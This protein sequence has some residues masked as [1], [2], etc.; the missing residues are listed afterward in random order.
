M[1]GLTHGGEMP[2]EEP[3]ARKEIPAASE[4][5][6]G[7][8]GLN[9][10]DT[11]TRKGNPVYNVGGNTWDYRAV[12]SKVGGTFYKP[13]PKAKGVYSFKGGDWENTAE[14]EAAILKG[15]A[16]AGLKPERAGG[17]VEKTKPTEET[18]ST[19]APA[20]PEEAAEYH[21]QVWGR[22]SFAERSNLI[23]PIGWAPRTANPMVEKSWDK[24]SPAAQKL[25]AK[26]I[27]E[28]ATAPQP[29][30]PAESPETDAVGLIGGS[31]VD[32]VTARG[33]HFIRAEM[34]PEEY[35]IITGITSGGYAEKLRE[36]GITARKFEDGSTVTWFDK[37]LE[38]QVTGKV[39][40]K[41]FIKEGRG[42]PLAISVSQELPGTT[43]R[44]VIDVRLDE[45][46]LKKVTENEVAFNVGDRVTW[47]DGIMVQTG[48]VE[49]L[50]R[51]GVVE[52]R[53][54][55]VPSESLD[56]GARHRLRDW[57]DKIEELKQQ[58][59]MRND[60]VLVYQEL[61]KLGM[62]GN[63]ANVGDV[64]RVMGAGVVKLRNVNQ[65][66]LIETASPGETAK[67]EEELVELYS[68][69]EALTVINKEIFNTA[70]ADIPTGNIIRGDIE[71]GN[72]DAARMT[73]ENTIKT[74]IVNM[75]TRH[76]KE[77]KTGLNV[78]NSVDTPENI[79]GLVDQVLTHYKQTRG[80]V[81]PPQPK[82]EVD[83]IKHY[84]DATF[85]MITES[86]RSSAL[87]STVVENNNKFNALLSLSNQVKD[88][89][90]MVFDDVFD[91]DNYDMDAWNKFNTQEYVENLAERLYN[92]YKGGAKGDGTQGTTNTGLSGGQNVPGAHQGAPAENVQG[93]ER[94]GGAG[95]SSVPAPG[96][97]NRDPGGRAEAGDE[98]V[99]GPGSGQRGNLSAGRVTGQNYRITPEDNVDTRGPTQKVRDNI[100][101]LRVL[102]QL[103]AEQR[104]AT[105]DEQQALVKYVGWGF[106]KEMFN[107]RKD[108]QFNAERKELKELLTDE[109]WAE[110]RHSSQFAHYTSPEAI[111]AIYTA[112]EHMGFRGGRVLEPAMGV[113]HFFGLIPEK[114]AGASW[115]TGVE[116][117]PTAG[118]M[119]KHLYPKANINVMG[120]QDFSVPY[121]K[122]K[123][124]SENYYDAIVSNVPF[125]EHRNFI[126]TRYDHLPGKKNLHNYF[127]VKAMDQLRPGGILAF[128]TSRYTMDSMDES[129]RTYMAEKADFLGAVRLHNRAFKGIA[130]TQ[131]VTDVIF[132]QK[133]APGAEAKMPAWIETEEVEFPNAEARSWDTT[134]AVNEYFIQNPD[135]VLGTPTV[136]KYGMYGQWEYTVDPKV[137]VKGLGDMTLGEQIVKA[138]KEKMPANIYKAAPKHKSTE[139]AS[140][141]QLMP[142]PAGSQPGSF[143]LKDGKLYSTSVSEEGELVTGAVTLPEGKV[144]ERI[145]GLIELR[146]VFDDL[147]KKELSSEEGAGIDAARTK[148]NQVYD[149]FVKKHDPI[150]SLS[151]AMA[152]SGDPSY[153][154]LS[155]L[156]IVDP[157]AVD[158]KGKS[159][160]KVEKAAIFKQRVIRKYEPA[161]SAENAQEALY[162]ALNETGRLNFD[163]MSDLT[164]LS[165]EQIQKD[166]T[167]LIYKDPEKG[168]TMGDEYLSG[169]VREKLRIA[170]DAAKHDAAF[171]PNV[172]ALR[173]VQPVDLKPEEIRV[174]FGSPWIPPDV[175]KAF[176][177]D[178][179][180]IP[181][182]NREHI[183][184]VHVRNLGA[185]A[186]MLKDRVKST[187]RHSTENTRTYGIPELSA[188]KII[189]KTFTGQAIK[190]YKTVQDPMTGE[191]KRVP[192]EVK[193]AA[194]Q[195]K[196]TLIVEKFRKWLWENPARAEMLAGKYNQEFN[197]THLWECDGSHMTFPG[198]SPV[199]TLE[200]YQKNAVYRALRGK[201]VGVFHVVG[202]GKTFVMVAA[203]MELKRIGVVNKPVMVVPNHL[204]NKTAREAQELYPAIN[205]L[206]LTNKD[207]EQ[208]SRKKAVARVVTGDWDMVIVPESAFITIPI[209]PKVTEA[210]INKQLA[211]IEEAILEHQAILGKEG[212]AIIR[213][214][215]NARDALEKKLRK[216]LA[217]LEEM[218]DQGHIMFEETGIDGVIVDESHRFKNLFYSSKMTRMG[219]LG[220]MEGSA[221]AFDLYIKTRHIRDMRGGSGI[222][223][224]TGTPVSNTMAELYHLQRY[225]DPEGLEERG[226]HTFDAWAAT[227]GEVVT[228][229]ELSPSGKGFRDKQ[230]F[231]K[232]INVPEM[233]QM[234]RSFA[235]VYTREQL[236]EKL[237]GTERRVPGMLGGKVL[238]KIAQPSPDLLGYIDDLDKRADEIRSGA[239]DKKVDNMLKVVID[240]QQV[241]LYGP[242]R[243]LPEYEGDKVSVLAEN[244]YDIWDKYKEKKL[245]QLVFLDLSTPKGKNK[246]QEAAEEEGKEVESNATDEQVTVYNVIRRRLIAKG[247]PA[248]DIAFIHDYKTEQQKEKLYNAMNRGSVRVLIGSTEKMGVGMN[249]QKLGIAIHHVDARWRP[250]DMEQREG[251]FLRQG[252][253]N[254]EV[255]IFAYTTERSFDTYM[256]QL[257]EMKQGFISVLF[258]KGANIREIED[259]DERTLSYAEVKAI[260]TGNPLLKERF[261]VGKELR[262]LHNLEEAYRGGIIRLQHDLAWAKGGADRN[263]EIIAQTKEAIKIR[264][265]KDDAAFKFTLKG[266]DYT[267]SY[268][269]GKAESR[270][271]VAQALQSLCSDI[272]RDRHFYTQ[273]AWKKAGYES[274]R[275]G[276]K[277]DGFTGTRTP[278]TE[279]VVIGEFA[280]FKLGFNPHTLTF[281]VGL[282]DGKELQMRSSD[283]A[284]TAGHRETASGTL[285]SLEG[286]IK[287]LDELLDATKE[288]I[289]EDAERA[290]KIEAEL[291]KPFEHAEVLR[292]TSQ[293]M[294][295]IEQELGIDKVESES[296][297]E[298]DLPDYTLEDLLDRFESINDILSGKDSLEDR[299][300]GIEARRDREKGAYHPERTSRPQIPKAFSVI[301]EK[302]LFPPG[303]VNLDIGGGKYDLGTTFFAERS[304]T[305]LVY[306]PYARSEEHNNGVLEALA[307]LGGM[308]DSVTSMNVL[309]VIEDKLERQEVVRFGYEMTPAEGLFVIQIYEG[310]GTGKGRM[311][312][313][314]QET[315]N[316]Q[317]NRKAKDY[318]KEIREAL[319]YGATVEFKHGL[320]LIKKHKELAWTAERPGGEVGK[321]IGGAMYVHKSA[322]DQLPAADQSIIAAAETLIPDTHKGYAVVKY[323]RALK[324]TSFIQSPDFDAVH[325]PTV[326]DSVRVD[327]DGNVKVTSART[328]NK[329]IYHHKWMMV[330]DD[331]TG[332][333]VAESKKRSEWWENTARDMN[334]DID[335]NRIGNLDNWISFLDDISL[336]GEVAASSKG[337]SPEDEL[338]DGIEKA[339]HP[340]PNNL[341]EVEF[342]FV[343]QLPEEIDIANPDFIHDVYEFL[344]LMDTEARY[345]KLK[346][347]LAQ[348]KVTPG[349]EEGAVFM[350]NMKNLASALHE[351]GHAT[352]FKMN[353]LKYP[354]SIR[355]RFPGVW[356]SEKELRQE[357]KVV[358]Q[359]MRPDPGGIKN[360]NAYR[361]RHTELMADY[362]MLYFVDPE[363]AYD[364]A[365]NV[366]DAFMDK[367]KGYPK[368]HRLIQ[369]LHRGRHDTRSEEGMKLSELEEIIKAQIK[370]TGKTPEQ[371]FLELAENPPADYI[372]ATKQIIVAGQRAAKAR[373]LQAQM[374]ASRWK[375]SVGNRRLEF[376]GAFVEGMY[377][378]KSGQ[379]YDE[380]EA[381]LTPE[382]KKIVKEYRYIK[383]LARQMLNEFLE[384]V[385]GPEYI[386]W[387]QDYILHMYTGTPKRVKAFTSKWNKNVKS[388]KERTFPTYAEAI[389]AGLTPL[390]QNLADLHV[391]WANINW[392]AAINQQIIFQLKNIQNEDGMPIIMKPSEAP[393]HW[394]TLHHPAIQKVYARKDKSGN[395]H[396]WR[397]GAAI[398][399]EAYKYLRPVFDQPLTYSIINIIET[400]NAYAKSVQLSLSLF[401]YWNLTESYQALLARW[402]NPLRGFVLIGGEEETLGTGWQIPGTNKYISRPHVAGKKALESDL[403]QGDLIM[404]GLA[405]EAHSDAHTGRVNKGLVALEARTRN[406]PGLKHLTMAARAYK[407]WFDEKLWNNFHAGGKAYVYHALCREAFASAKR[408]LT[409]SEIKETKQMLA[410]LINDGIGGQEWE[411]KFWAGPKT[412]QILQIAFL[413]PDYSIS[414]FNIARKAV[415]SL[416]PKS[417][418]SGGGGFAGGVGRKVLWK[419]WIN[420]MLSMFFIM[421]GA[422]Y[423]I[424]KKFIWQNEWGKKLTID[425][426]PLMKTLPWVDKDDERR[427]YI[428]PG[429]QAREVLRYVTNP[430]EVLGAKSSPFAQLVVEQFTGAKLGQAGW[431][432]PWV[433]DDLSFYESLPP[434]IASVYDKFVP[435]SFRGNNFALAFPMRRGMGWWQAQRAYEDA[436]RAAVDP[437]IY[438]RLMSEEQQ[439]KAFAEITAAAE[440]NGLDHQK[441]FQQANTK[442]KSTYY[443]ALWE[444]WNKGDMEEAERIAKILF[445]L[446][447]TPRGTRQS[448][449]RRMEPIMHDLYTAWS[450]GDTEK[451]DKLAEKL[452]ALGAT[453]EQIRKYFESRAE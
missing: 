312:P 394:P 391:M 381:S 225:L 321:N 173:A 6:L 445:Q 111:S 72:E 92:Y 266:K 228:S 167:G 7:D 430:F 165:E 172:E 170:E 52:V 437:K 392:K 181:Y 48:T 215:E 53:E 309:N 115:L 405:I 332:F 96:A 227:F 245:T 160:L 60:P 219:G 28:Q 265:D 244:V 323:A 89:Q 154:K 360:F 47:E 239:V 135:M 59:E 15:L 98:S 70:V 73:L 310:D 57:I 212:K 453:P 122:K 102:K 64:S 295:E 274:A 367:I 91:T 175:Y 384:N 50:Q 20:A 447:V 368:V 201:S 328:K 79:A 14:L 55:I 347:A 118:N 407:V 95:A 226:L 434:R 198:M 389:E 409:A 36:A 18:A 442:V 145:L 189:E 338:Y 166:L 193:T 63:D 397:G 357:L 393:P 66:R 292:G 67:T 144:K 41:P 202:S 69:R 174:T 343:R 256:W 186:L 398:D 108:D 280:G 359:F 90:L 49:Y 80:A 383:E 259:I 238:V 400:F 110:A 415:Q 297:E 334:V 261:E 385:Q 289:K 171:K 388:A 253:V 284:A 438:Q 305:N 124:L 419:Y 243:G 216:H 54:D 161:I 191:E 233:L 158:A 86:K 373:P 143:F 128:I 277:V 361:R 422:N 268:K 78:Y 109:E 327:A 68:K 320:F 291:A 24:L 44:L 377:E 386:K 241:A 164:G 192:D 194:A 319:P 101:A 187:L 326:G 350:A 134:K 275:I 412:R 440:L 199:I 371:E 140:V 271:K 190:I 276:E 107:E 426:T 30:G 413:A 104:P 324:T 401:H 150:N 87:L 304:I 446:G 137:E 406:I 138:V 330:K 351:G 214:I 152:F 313:G 376:L 157:D 379:T 364:M 288:R 348:T 260:T 97:G 342:D 296:V 333:N 302:N 51:A 341:A 370:T 208:K 294:K 77:Q 19:Q 317:E 329:Q 449:S 81:T 10:K 149:K 38:K 83:Y 356:A 177:I 34:S 148:L 33:Y 231:A 127:F 114:M 76:A 237:A 168:W 428:T 94:G 315:Y 32:Q 420:M 58:R 221:K 35:M 229:L 423:L 424:N 267:E 395:M 263:T 421:N 432:M 2:A 436:I 210:F 9:I 293:R 75:M 56:K 22:M 209:S 62:K 29:K 61:K 264:I 298:S 439:G 139:G 123:L 246:E 410:E 217:S 318:L 42:N 218:Q 4:Y 299:P 205:M 147:I 159:I 99:S 358:S 450:R 11:V 224:A 355:A 269:A 353:D 188:I 251:R 307:N 247:I 31:R 344:R 416:N 232:F 285:R 84:E 314:A 404:A 301:V 39:E 113:G 12:L 13:H 117:E 235:D 303:T 26:Q 185:W 441:M 278:I 155:G 204:V 300:G 129:F 311:V 112:L 207:L 116:I 272:H 290:A 431:V 213:K 346:K 1:L 380:I 125:S 349:Q 286:G 250:A 156:E 130:E 262:R 121:D 27:D 444:A 396:L 270:E 120:Y 374:E 399:P 119:A 179:L 240:G 45:P 200:P 236:V 132:M 375:K 433:E 163:R 136:Q 46:T 222:I 316:W 106:N 402:W 366:T 100:A 223:F 133:R 85:K 417:R 151:N 65:L 153:Y 103:E 16:E 306:D 3:A 37:Q 281:S 337:F 418:Y 331:Y 180:N 71:Q 252:N 372:D 8:Y 425:V 345:K 126:D 378:I 197:H 254:D 220:K 21:A 283:T 448:F 390:T 146:E 255:M 169:N 105:R 279:T 287:S 365:P 339:E 184:V 335:R 336:P 162:I 43:S 429:K 176:I 382:E 25:I 451:A 427:F 74:I 242:L 141:T 23:Q 403:F 5:S 182:H 435:F 411:S 93:T 273:N 452:I 131:V 195:E 178:L 230:R 82:T 443:A 234:Y 354:S 142:A 258:R 196:Q 352:D 387:V 322:V 362:Y 408:P 17:E 325:E 211:L 40:G 369:E 248:K 249:V 414:N 206:V 282:K 88:A 257:L 363:L 308:P 203:A 183:E 340:E